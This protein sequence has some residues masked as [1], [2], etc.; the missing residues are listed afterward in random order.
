MLADQTIGENWW[1]LL[2]LPPT[3]PYLTPGEPY[4]EF[5]G[6]EGKKITK[7]LVFSSWMATPTAIATLLSYRADRLAAGPK[8]TGTSPDERQT[9]WNNRR[10]WLAYGMD[11]TNTSRPARMATLAL[12]WPMPGLA[13]LADPLMHRR[14]APGPVSPQDLTRLVADQLG[15]PDSADPEAKEASHWWEAF[16]RDDSLPP[17]LRNDSSRLDQIVAALKGESDDDLDDDEQ[18]SVER[19]N[20][21]ARHVALAFECAETPQDRHVSDAVRVQLAEVAAHS[22]ANIAYRVLA[23]ISHGQQRVTDKGLWIAAAQLGS[24]LRTLFAR[25]ETTLLLSQLMPDQPYWRSVLQY[26]AAGNLQAVM[27]EYLY[28][29]LVAQGKPT[30]DDKRLLA[31]ADTAGSAIALRPA[32]YEV[33]DPQR[34]QERPKLSAQFALRY[35]GRRVEQESVRLPQVRQ[36]FNSPFRPFVLASTSVGQEGIDFHWWCHAILHWNTP[37]SPIDFE[38]REGRID[39]YDGHAVRLNLVQRHAEE[40]L[41]AEDA[42]P[43]EAAYRIAAEAADASLGAFAPHWVYPGTAKI[44][45]HVAPFALSND[46]VRLARV[47]KDVALY[48]LTFGQPRQED[49][50]ELLNQRYS[51]ADPSDLDEMRVDLSPPR[52]S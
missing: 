12:F 52:R 23:R 22:P 15:R 39:R 49:M 48:R 2:W 47:K 29:L 26:C 51:A 6:P 8:W 11:S 19:G 9:E 20:V 38:Q 41:A 13:E 37:A 46:E 31:I 21:L 35:G 10:K 28:H 45:R 25:P 18:P 36:A 14:R 44:E 40:I 27:D 4:A 32:N 3:L 7:R 50:L 34:P 24:S 1:K 30:L 33:F 5:G 17:A 42:D 16:A 43:W